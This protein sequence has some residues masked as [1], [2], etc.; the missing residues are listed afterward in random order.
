MSPPNTHDLMHHIKSHAHYCSLLW[1]GERFGHIQKLWSHS[2][3]AALGVSRSAGLWPSERRR[4]SQRVTWKTRIPHQLTG[5]SVLDEVGGV[6]LASAY[7]LK[8]TLK[9]WRMSFA[10]GVNMG[11]TSRH[12]GKNRSHTNVWLMFAKQLCFY[13]KPHL[14]FLFLPFYCFAMVYSVHLYRKCINWGF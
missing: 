14:F 1:H 5:A 2:S 3:R 9:C 7:L 10:D 12:S 11:N 13:V 4:S 8:C 6:F